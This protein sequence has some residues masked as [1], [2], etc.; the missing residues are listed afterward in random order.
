MTVKEQL[1]YDLNGLVS[2]LD[3]LLSKTGLSGTDVYSTEIGTSAAYQLS[4]AWGLFHIWLRPSSE[5]QGDW[6]RSWGDKRDLAKMIAAI[7]NKFAPEDNP[8][9]ETVSVISDATNLW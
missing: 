1:K 3:G 7:F 4:F 6:S 2:D 5:S 8:L 9:V